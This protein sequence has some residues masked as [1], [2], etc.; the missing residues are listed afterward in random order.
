MEGKVNQYYFDKMKNSRIII[1]EEIYTMLPI[2]DT[3]SIMISN[4]PKYEKKFIFETEEKVVDDEVEF[5]KNFRN[6]KAENN[7]TKEINVMFNTEDDNELIVKM[8][9]LDDKLVKEPLGKKAYKVLY[10]KNIEDLCK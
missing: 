8:L 7:M 3:D 6:V 1:T 9:K 5:I 10:V 4:Y 2:K